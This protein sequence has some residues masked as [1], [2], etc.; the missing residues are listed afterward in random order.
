MSLEGR[1]VCVFDFDYL[2]EQFVEMQIA[3]P[4]GFVLVRAYVKGCSFAD[5]VSPVVKQSDDDGDSSFAL[6]LYP[7]IPI[8]CPLL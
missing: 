7:P 8:L 4:H 5:A 2:N 6:R 1:L 3:S